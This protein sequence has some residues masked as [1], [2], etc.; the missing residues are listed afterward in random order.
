MIAAAIALSSGY[1]G[2]FA[3]TAVVYTIVAGVAVIVVRTSSAKQQA[4]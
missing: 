1:R 2:V 4:A 3:G